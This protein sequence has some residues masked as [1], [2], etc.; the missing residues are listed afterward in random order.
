MRLTYQDFARGANV[1]DNVTRAIGGHAPPEVQ[2]H[3]ST[4]SSDE[5]RAALATVI[6]VATGRERAAA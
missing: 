4:V 1:A 6:D 5:M 3:T 2:R